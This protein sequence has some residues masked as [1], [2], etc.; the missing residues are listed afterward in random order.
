M[1]ND[2]SKPVQD[3]NN[4]KNFTKEDSYKNLDRANFWIQNADSKTSFVLAFVGVFLTLFFSSNAI[5]GGIK[6][7]KELLSNIFGTEKEQ[8]I[9]YFPSLVILM[10]VLAVVS[11]V[12]FVIC[13]I[14]GIN[15]LFSALTATVNAPEAEK[16]NLFF[17]SIQKKRNG[18]FQEELG[19]L[20]SDDLLWDINTQTHINSQIAMKKFQFYNKGLNLIKRSFVFFIGFIVIVYLFNIV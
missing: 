10:V 9:V 11:L 15:N 19:N 6:S 4:R 14:R 8:A 20:S 3:E 18:E 17:G 16:S 7:A 5:L 13:L 1:S 12:L 2:G